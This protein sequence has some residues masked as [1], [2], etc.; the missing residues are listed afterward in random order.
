MV[1]SEQREILFSRERFSYEHNR[2]SIHEF[3]EQKD[4]KAL[5]DSRMFCTQAFSIPLNGGPI[6]RV[7][8]DQ[9]LRI[10]DLIDFRRDQH[11]RCFMIKD[12]GLFD[13]I[14]VAG[15]V[16]NGFLSSH[17]SFWDRVDFCIEEAKRNMYN[18]IHSKSRWQ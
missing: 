18:Q 16:M 11:E 14:D 7:V 5:I 12:L 3:W 2:A 4:I 8:S 1:M 15:T 17:V 13:R 6:E 9:E 10:K